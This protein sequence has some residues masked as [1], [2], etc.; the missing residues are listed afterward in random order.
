MFG[1][2]FSVSVLVLDHKMLR[3][4]LSFQATSIPLLALPSSLMSISTSGKVC[5]TLFLNLIAVRPQGSTQSQ[6]S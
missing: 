6:F 2:F 5:S 3:F 4:P 1:D